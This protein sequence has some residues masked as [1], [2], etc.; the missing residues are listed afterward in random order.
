MR[1]KYEAT[2][3]DGIDDH[4]DITVHAMERYAYYV[5]CK[6]QKVSNFHG[7]FQNTYKFTKTKHFR[8]TMEEKPDAMLSLVKTL[9]PRNSYAEVA[10]I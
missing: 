1:F 4:K 10:A 6:C 8:L 3:R 7:L 9:T 2:N 5:C